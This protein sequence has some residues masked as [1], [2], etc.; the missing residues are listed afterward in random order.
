MPK[1]IRVPIELRKLLSRF[2]ALDQGQ[3]MLLKPLV[4]SILLWSFWAQLMLDMWWCRRKSS[5]PYFNHFWPQ[6]M[7]GLEFFEVLIFTRKRQCLIFICTLILLFLIPAD[8]GQALPWM[9]GT[10]LCKNIY[11]HFEPT[12]W[13]SLYSS[14]Y[15]GYT[16]TLGPHFRL[17]FLTKGLLGLLNS[18]F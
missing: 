1:V 3:F 12:Q 11:N 17:K 9:N 2:A 15:H 18:F 5:S 4:I 8:L 6:L 7:L 14:H 16:S 10:L 13:G